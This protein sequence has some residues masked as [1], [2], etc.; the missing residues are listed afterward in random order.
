MADVLPQNVTVVDDRAGNHFWIF[1]INHVTGA[2]SDILVENSII[3]ASH[4]T[5]DGTRGVDVKLNADDSATDAVKEIS[6]PSATA[7][8]TYMIVARF[9]GTAGTGS[10]HENL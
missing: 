2:D 9:G 4:L 5:D 3:S 10:G 1:T 6:F 7:S 8:G